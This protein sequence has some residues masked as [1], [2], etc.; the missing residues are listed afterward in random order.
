MRR[1]PGCAAAPAGVVRDNCMNNTETVGEQLRMHGVNQEVSMGAGPAELAALPGFT[2]RRDGIARGLARS[3]T[4]T[5]G[6][7]R[8]LLTRCT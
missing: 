4:L 3:C 8:S 6:V 2:A 5:H 1:A 7:A